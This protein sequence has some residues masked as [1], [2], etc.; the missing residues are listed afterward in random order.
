ML[1]DGTMERV[2]EEDSDKY[3][4]YHMTGYRNEDYRNEKWEI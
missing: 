3:Q 2:V 4:L 1:A